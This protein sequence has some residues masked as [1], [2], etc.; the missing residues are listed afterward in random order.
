M[1]KKRNPRI[2]SRN[3][4]LVPGIT[5]LSRS[6]SARAKAKYLHTKKGA[7][8]KQTPKKVAAVTIREKFYPADDARRAIPSRKSHQKIVK[9][10]K[11]I[12]PGT[13]LILL[14]GRFRGKR[15]V[16]LKQLTSGLLLINGPFAI[17][18]VPLRRVNQ[19]YVIATQTKVDVTKVDVAAINDEFFKKEETKKEEKKEIIETSE[20]KKNV[21]A[22]SRKNAQEKV[23]AAMAP[24]VAAVPQLKQYLNAKFTLTKGQYPHAMSF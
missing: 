12:T 17:N 15:V 6:A 18:G 20:K 24:L 23:D 5:R 10:R 19:A 22:T 11:S 7:K 13:V 21:L 8:G 4:Q 9:L 14:A 16:F 1:G 3:E 2:V